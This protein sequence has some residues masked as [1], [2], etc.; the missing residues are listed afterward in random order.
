M[1]SI[2][3]F[4]NGLRS[5]LTMDSFIRTRISSKRYQEAYENLLFNYS[6][7]ETWTKSIYQE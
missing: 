1:T 5:I 2:D 3:G 6:T 4:F 7:I